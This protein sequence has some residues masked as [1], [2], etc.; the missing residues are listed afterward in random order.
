MGGVELFVQKVSMSVSD[1][2]KFRFPKFVIEGIVEAGEKV[3]LLADLMKFPSKYR[4]I[5][6]N[7]INL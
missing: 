3:D 6:E 2:N 4:V 7:R 5:V 1:E